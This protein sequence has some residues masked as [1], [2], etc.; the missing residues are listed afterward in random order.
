MVVDILRS[1]IRVVECTF[2]RIH[3]R[4]RACTG[5]RSVAKRKLIFYQ[6]FA[7]SE[8]F[9]IF[10]LLYSIPVVGHNHAYK[11]AHRTGLPAIL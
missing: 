11:A 6:A 10:F 1:D 9:T 5:I 7:K 3:H 2:H 4:I 8:A